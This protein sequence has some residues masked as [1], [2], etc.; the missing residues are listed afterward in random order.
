MAMQ[1]LPVQVPEVHTIIVPTMDTAGP[2]EQCPFCWLHRRLSEVSATSEKIR[3]LRTTSLAT[4]S[5][6]RSCCRRWWR[7]R[8][9]SCSPASPA[10]GRQFGPRV[11]RNFLKLLK[12]A[13][14]INS[15]SVGQA[16][17]RIRGHF[18]RD[19]LPCLA[20]FV[21]PE[22]VDRRVKRSSVAWAVGFLC[23][24]RWS[25]SRSC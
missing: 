5:A 10:L 14:L 15:E 3:R 1:S 21:P 19:F 11:Q 18:C 12:L 6:L 17:K 13:S 7:P 8:S 2:S 4:R 25:F 22:S 20:S 23:N 9:T 24:V 16:Q